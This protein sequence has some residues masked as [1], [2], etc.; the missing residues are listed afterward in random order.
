MVLV[1]GS[2]TNLQAII[3]ACEA[4]EINGDVVAVI[5]NVVGVHS[6]ERA[7]K[8]NI[9]AIE[10]PHNSFENRALFDR[11]LAQQVL[12]FKPDIVVLAGFMRILSLDFVNAFAGKL[13]N[14]HP[15]LLPKYPG[16]HT[17]K[18]ALQNNDEYHGCSIHF[19][20]AELDGGPIVIQS[21]VPILATDTLQT[22]QSKVAA[23]EW[24]IYPLILNW[25]CNER[26]RLQNDE[27]WLDNK[28][29]N[30]QGILYEDLATPQR[31]CL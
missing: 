24:I 3:D 17:H 12:H 7:K 15:S 30:K 29:I 11:E 18:K 4:N 31:P 20:T 13:L 8:H 9:P 16:L 26:L 23:R 22:L 14:I 6:M 25:F 27:V 28:K 1:S 5:S 10:L 21:R 2:G 19:V